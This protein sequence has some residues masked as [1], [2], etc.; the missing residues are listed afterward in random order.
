M[1]KVLIL[2]SRDIDSLISDVELKPEDLQLW[3]FNA[4][5]RCI[6]HEFDEV[7]FQGTHPAK[8]AGGVNDRR[9]ISTTIAS[10][11]KK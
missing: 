2:D 4:S 11:F 9:T 10:N 1:K 5:V 8:Q 3:H 6:A 7:I